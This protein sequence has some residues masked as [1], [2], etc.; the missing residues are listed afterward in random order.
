MF[1]KIIFYVKKN[2]NFERNVLLK[3]SNNKPTKIN[4]KFK[5]KIYSL[6]YSLAQNRMWSFNHNY[7]HFDPLRGDVSNMSKLTSNEQI[8]Q[9]FLTIFLFSMFN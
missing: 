7:F 3:R 4:V 2:L 5:A 8:L 1:R 9:F 6:F